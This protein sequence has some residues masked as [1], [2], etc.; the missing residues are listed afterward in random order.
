MGRTSINLT[1]VAPR[2]HCGMTLVV[3]VNG[4]NAIWLM[5]DR[6]LSWADGSQ[7]DD[8]YKV[9]ALRRIDGAAILG[10]AVLG[11]TA[12]GSEPSTWMESVLRPRDVP[13]E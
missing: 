6:R 13:L 8:H 3:S 12:L 2:K 1:A 9:M 7:R 11:L 4:P 10:Y 5:A